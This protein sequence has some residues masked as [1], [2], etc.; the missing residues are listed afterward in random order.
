MITPLMIV[1]R[2]P[3]AL[4][5]VGDHAWLLARQLRDCHDIHFSFLAAGI[6]NDSAAPPDDFPV[7]R[8][9]ARSSRSLLDFLATTGRGLRPIVLHLSSYGYHKRATPLWL[10]RAVR[11]LSRARGGPGLIVMC[12]ELYSSGPITTSAFWTQPLQKLVVRMVVHAADVART[13]IATHARLLGEVA[14]LDPTKV[15]AMPIFSN[16]GELESPPPLADR[17]AEMV[18]FCSGVHGGADISASL[19]E[20]NLIARRFA[21]GKLHLIG[22]ERPDAAS[23]LKLPFEHHSYLPAEAIGAILARCRIAYNGYPARYLAKSGI[24]AA[25]AAHGLAVFAPGAGL[26]DDLP[27]GLRFGRELLRANDKDTLALLTLGDLQ[28]AAAN[29]ARWYRGHC[30]A[31]TAESYAHDIEL[32]ASPRGTAARGASLSALPA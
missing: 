12:H 8:L 14:G 13:N 10:A 23:R 28:S 22:K 20:V 11:H 5:G 27:D 4:C 17:P 1:P 31:R 9:G 2:V 15:I 19:Q 21:I 32:V 26:S 6:H 16:F 25:H 30:L 24:F 18:M 29:I 7:F 3:P